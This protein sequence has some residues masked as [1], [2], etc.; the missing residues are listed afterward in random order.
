MGKWIWMHEKEGEF[1]ENTR[2]CFADSFVVENVEEEITLEICA[3]TKYM[4]Y[5]NGSY[6]GRGPIRGEKGSFT[7]DSYSI[8]PLCRMGENTIAVRVW[9][10]GW[11]TYQSISDTPGVDFTA[12]QGGHILAESGETTRCREDLGHMRYA[13]KRN[14]NLGFSDYYDGRKGNLKWIA[15]SREAGDW[16]YGKVLPRKGEQTEKKSRPI[17]MLHSTEVYPKKV[18][19]IQDVKRGCQQL[20]L[21][22]RRAFFGDRRDANET[23]F[24][25]FLGGCFTAEKDMEGMIS[26]P[27]RTWNGIIGTFRLGGKVYPVDNAHRD[28]PVQIPAGQQFFLM[29]ISGKFDD[30]YCHIELR[31]P[32]KLKTGGFFTVGPTQRICQKLDGV[33]RIYGGLDEF[34]EMESYTKKHRRI[35]EAQSLEELQKLTDEIVF[36]DEKDIFEDMYLLSLARTEEVVQEY[37]VTTEDCG[38]LWKNQSCTCL[39]Y[40]SPSPRD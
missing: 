13:P 32:E 23:I 10:Y 35:F 11:S 21:N 33:S 27:N 38:I 16:G 29:Q 25:G 19:C 30:L 2:A 5:I 39:L 36:L 28:I 7:Y 37:A 3:V 1:R 31:F 6:V 40:T 8:L 15:D 34:N 20:T 9:N 22:T 12:A 14:V 4:V 17:R 18:E 26:F 24:S